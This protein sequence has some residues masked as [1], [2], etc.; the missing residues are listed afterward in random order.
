MYEIADSAMTIY[1]KT[2]IH[3]DDK[4][5]VSQACMSV[6]Q[7]IKDFGYIAIEPCMNLVFL[8]FI[9]CAYTNC[10]WMNKLLIVLILL[11]L[12]LKFRHASACGV[13][14]GIASEKVSLS[15]SKI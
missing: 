15:A 4:E 1:I 9:I 12:N 3:D 6:A 14:S 11:S 2:M 5:V 8:L 7:I 10:S 13:D